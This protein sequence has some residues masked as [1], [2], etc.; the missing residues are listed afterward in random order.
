MGVGHCWK[1]S[2]RENQSTQR[3]SCPSATLS[4]IN[5]TWTDTKS[6]P[7]FTLMSEKKKRLNQRLLY[8]QKLIFKN[9][10][11][12]SRKTQNS[13]KE[14]N[15]L[16]GIVQVVCRLARGRT[17]RGS[18]SGGGRDFPNP[19]R[20]SLGPIESRAQWVPVHFLGGKAAGE[21]S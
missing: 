11:F 2:V 21:W 4:T 18:N 1:E 5:L 15:R 16:R 20:S 13:S 10:V 14:T 8:P 6:N 19:S 9:L 7:D 3:H 17:V 12:A